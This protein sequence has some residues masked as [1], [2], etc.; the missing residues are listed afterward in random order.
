MHS[1]KNCHW[2]LVVFVSIYDVTLFMERKT[3]KGMYNGMVLVWS[4]STRVLEGA[5][6]S[7]WRTDLAN[8]L[9]NVKGIYLQPVFELITDMSI[10]LL[11]AMAKQ[12]CLS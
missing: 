3:M 2:H 8:F 4:S 1:D 7:Y 5:K 10:D 6:L 12:R 9:D 11:N